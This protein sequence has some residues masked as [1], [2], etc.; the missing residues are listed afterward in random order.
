MTKD[1]EAELIIKKLRMTPQERFEEN[2]KILYDTM[3]EEIMKEI[4]EEILSSILK[5][6][7][8]N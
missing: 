5:V 1:E 2:S 7:F 4:D 3:A 8:D 6:N